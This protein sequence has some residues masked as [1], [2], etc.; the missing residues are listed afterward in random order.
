M[1]FQN[2]LIIEVIAVYSIYL[3]VSDDLNYPVTCYNYV[4]HFLR[5]CGPLYTANTVLCGSGSETVA[6]FVVKP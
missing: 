5:E 6:V 1:L 2:Y 4:M 3:F